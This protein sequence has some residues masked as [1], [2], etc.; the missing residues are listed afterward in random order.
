MKVLFICHGN[1]CRSI[2]AQCIMEHKLKNLDLDV[3]VDSMACSYEEQGNS[4]YPLAKKKLTDH[5]IEI[6]PHQARR[7]E[8]NDYEKY[9]YILC[10]DNSNLRRLNSICLDTKH[11]YKLLLEY[12]GVN[13]EISDPW[14]NGDFE[15]A[16]LE[17]TK[18]I[19]GFIMYLK[20][21]HGKRAE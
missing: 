13:K 15:T 14:Y 21:L 3:S 16:Y 5:H 7:F 11:K 19:D 9:D 2:M 1:I 8:K 20:N 4:I 6:I 10:M 18:G 12:T 17:I